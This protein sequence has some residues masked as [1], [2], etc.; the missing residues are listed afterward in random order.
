MIE[1]DNEVHRARI[2]WISEVGLKICCILI[3]AIFLKKINNNNN[4][5]IYIII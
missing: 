4:M 5:L 1:L 3:T 2:E